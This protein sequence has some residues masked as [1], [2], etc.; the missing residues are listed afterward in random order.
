MKTSTLPFLN[1][2]ILPNLKSDFE[3]KTSQYCLSERSRVCTVSNETGVPETWKSKD[4]LYYE[5]GSKHVPKYS[6]SRVKF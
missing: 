3:T 4:G 2:G 6:K 1:P 5:K